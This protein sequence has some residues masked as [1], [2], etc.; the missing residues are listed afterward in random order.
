MTNVGLIIFMLYTLVVL[1]WC[2]S[3]SPDELSYI[4]ISPDQLDKWKIIA[5]NLIIFD[6]RMRRRP[7]FEYTEIPDVFQVSTMELPDMLQWI[8][9]LTTVVFCGGRGEISRLGPR[10]NSY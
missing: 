4:V 1:I 7:D 9:P 8:P 5:P 2:T 10:L 6:L 3:Q